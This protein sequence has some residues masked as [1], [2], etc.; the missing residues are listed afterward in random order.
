[1][2]GRC[3]LGGSIYGQ[4]W[5]AMEGKAPDVESPHQLAAFFNTVQTLLRDDMLLAYHDRSDG[6]LFVTLSE[7]M[8]AGHVGLT[9]DLQELVIERKNTQ[10]IIDDFVL[11]TQ[12][13]ATHGR[14]MRVLFNEELGA[15]LQVKKSDT[16]E[17]ISRFM[18]AGIGRELFV[19]GRVNNKDR[20]VI[21]HRGAE[22]FNESRSDLH[23]EWSETSARMQ[24]L[25]DNP[26]CADSEHLLR[27]SPKAPGLS[28]KLSFDVHADP[29]A[30]F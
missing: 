27:S 12:Q 6:G 25:R 29:A 5:K 17:V 11:P 1:G 22:L 19:I 4:V 18:K 20:L 26:A 16:P 2:Y 30:P 28:A 3:R 10:R 7:M 24:R 14:L 23:R 8:F 21:K 9:V 15:V 13:A